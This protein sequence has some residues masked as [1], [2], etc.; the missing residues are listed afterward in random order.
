MR[1]DESKRKRGDII[2]N[3]KLSAAHILLALIIVNR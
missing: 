2:M 1:K 3:G